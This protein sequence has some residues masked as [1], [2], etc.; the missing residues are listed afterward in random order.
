MI[1]LKKAI[2]ALVFFLPFCAVSSHAFADRSIELFLQLGHTG[3]VSSVAFSPDG[4]RLASGS[5]DSTVN[6]WELISGA[7]K[8]SMALLPGNEWIA[9]HPQKW[10]YNASLQG[11]EYAA[12]R[13]ENQLRPV[14]PLKY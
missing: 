6:V 7:I 12:I 14:Y 10:V 1:P 5:F 11:D 13:F 8:V 2:I 9:Y 3:S 4:K